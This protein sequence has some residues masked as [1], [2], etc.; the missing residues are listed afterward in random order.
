[1]FTLDI[2][3][4][5]AIFMYFQA[6]IIQTDSS[7]ISQESIVSDLRSK[8]NYT[9]SEIDKEILIDPLAGEVNSIGIEDLREIMSEI[10]L[11]TEG[12][13][14]LLIK[15][16]EKM[17]VDAQNFML[18]TLEEPYDNLVI[19]LLT[20]NPEA[21]LATILSRV[22]IISSQ[23]QEEKKHFESF[24]SLNFADRI[25]LID[26][27]ANSRPDS[28]MFLEN[29]LRESVNRRIGLAKMEE[30]IKVMKGIKRSASIKAGLN[31]I[32]ILLRDIS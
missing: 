29:L 30:I 24:Y 18:K 14:L 13:K 17:T 25:E 23:N 1:M 3:V 10:S 19:V 2:I 15:S 11:R 7:D 5:L 31:R 9:I 16:S 28:V 4:H 26:K 8:L 27:L 32:N 22:L 21:F 6:V 12:I 20:S